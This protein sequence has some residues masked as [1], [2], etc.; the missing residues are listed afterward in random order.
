[1]AVGPAKIGDVLDTAAV[2]KAYDIRGTVPDQLTVPL[3]RKIGAAYAAFVRQQE[4]DTIEIALGRDMRESG[5]ELSRAFADGVLEQ[6]LG[7][8][9]LGLASTDLLYFASGQL[10]V[11]GIMF[12]ASHNPAGY[13]GIKSCLSA[14]VPIGVESGLAEI[15]AMVHNPPTPASTPGSERHLDMLDAFVAHVHSFVDLA[16]FRPF[17][18]VADTANGMGGLVVPAVFAGLPFDLEIMYEE[19]DGTFPNHEANPIDVANQ[20]DL[21]ARVTE[22]GADIGLAF[23]GDA[24]RVFVVDELAQP[25]SGS[26]LTAMVASRLL[27][28]NPGGTIIHN[29]ICSAAVGEV[30]AEAGGSAVVSRV[31]HSYIKQLMA[32]TG[33]IF[34]G[35]HSG[36]YY[37]RDNFRADSGLIAALI[38]LEIVCESD[39]PLSELRKPFERYWQSGEINSVVAD[40]AAIV[41]LVKNHYSHCEQDNLDGL[42]VKGDAWWF[43]LRSS[44]TEPLL[45]LNLEAADA[46]AGNALVAEV[47]SLI[48]SQETAPSGEAMTLDPRLLE[49]LACP[50]DK[51]PLLWIA[52]ESILYNPRLTRSYEVKDNI[53]VML[54]DEATTVEA[55]E[56]D[57]LMAKVEADGIAPTFSV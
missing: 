32:E 13:N 8:I 23:D 40:A 27:N 21:M 44:N 2:F 51:G 19:L 16:N 41:Q 49:I 53:P 17:K 56:H 4:P 12:T 42:T 46:D 33:A 57:R 48:N 45:R 6:G 9:W 11:P 52:D 34:A 10:D 15:E 50:E 54:V 35:E 36:H 29:L 39:A 37:F 28:E 14:A 3:A 22:V 5:I 31:G 25:L 47:R 38:V 30:A 18:V 20:A 43:N 24:D 1:M 55:A 7:V 26:T